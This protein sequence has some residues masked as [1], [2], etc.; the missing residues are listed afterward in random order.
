MATPPAL[1]T[2]SRPV[3]ARRGILAR[4][5]LLAALVIGANLWTTHHLGWGLEEPFGLAG[6]SGG[7]AIVTALLEK[8]V[9]TGE[10]EVLEIP[11]AAIPFWL[12]LLAYFACGIIAAT[13]SSVMVLNDTPG[14]PLE[15]TLRRADTGAVLPPVR[16]GKPDE[17]VRYPV[18]TS[19]F[20]RPYRVKV[21][22]YMEQTF[23]V[24]PLAGVT[25]SPRRDLRVSPS[26]LFRPP[27][28]ALAEL[29]PKSSAIFQVLVAGSP[30][31]QLA[32]DSCH[33][34]SF[35]V[36]REQ[37]VPAAWPD[38][39]KLE[40]ESLGFG[41]TD[42]DSA[43]TRLAW[44]RFTPLNPNQEIE[45]N[46]TLEARVITRAKKIIARARVKL[47]EEKLVDVPMFE[48]DP[49]PSVQTLPEAP[50]CGST[51]H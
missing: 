14:T 30:P 3:D 10:K 21:A 37:E 31:R 5:V 1:A 4:A 43:K 12:L 46:L 19:P 45:P 6:L 42:R 22:G 32:V 41:D 44:M 49:S 23:E 25:I 50:T 35:L 18:P 40:T 26:V 39:W 27:A 8:W 17:L 9:H 16:P 33:A 2:G 24:Y 20:G 48:E 34:S 51:R 36:G 38:L 15:V 28:A 11:L 47:R 7:V 13:R 29:D